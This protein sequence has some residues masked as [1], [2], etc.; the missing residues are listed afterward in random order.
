MLADAQTQP[1]GGKLLAWMAGAVWQ[2]GAVVSC[3]LCSLSFCLKCE[4]KKREI[5]KANSGWKVSSVLAY[6]GLTLPLSS[7]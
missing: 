2:E 5:E 6:E 3:S 7:K 1:Q 4:A